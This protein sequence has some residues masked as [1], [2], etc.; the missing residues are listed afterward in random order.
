MSEC[1]QLN[2]NLNEDMEELFT[3]TI[4]NIQEYIEDGWLPTRTEMY[5][6]DIYQM[7]K[8]KNYKNAGDNVTTVMY[9]IRK[10]E[11]KVDSETKSRELLTQLGKLQT[12]IHNK[13]NYYN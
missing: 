6:K 8:D 1:T 3:K 4:S 13:S 5:I 10:N 12:Q 11:S 9:Y 2:T 7:C